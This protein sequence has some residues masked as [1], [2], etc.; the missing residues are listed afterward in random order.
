MTLLLTECSQAGV[1]MV[2]DS[3]ISMVKN[4]K[5]KEVINEEWEKVLQAPRIGAAVGYWGEIG[6]IY[7]GRFDKW[8]KGKID[9]AEYGNLPSLADSLA[10][11]LNEACGNRE[12]A[13]NQCVGLHVAG[14]H[15]WED[16]IRRAYVFHVHNGHGRIEETED[17]IGWKFDRRTLF[18][19]HQEFPCT[20]RT[21]E[22][23]RDFIENGGWHLTRNGELFYYLKL[24]EALDD[25][26][27]RLNQIKGFRI[28]R[29]NSLGA[30]RGLL[31]VA[32]ETMIRLYAC[33][34]RLRTVGGR[35]KA[36][37]IDKDRYWL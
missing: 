27:A 2:A 11:T 19:V 13:D 31:V 17:E 16:G 20:D 8:L 3:A 14:F 25:A 26:F 7:P 4:G 18:E 29:D 5:I 10:K 37:S 21:L 23:N 35:A 6:R 33:S 24:S 15:S 22:Q 32:V 12:L 30:R 28:P 36:I 1:V 9:R 34:N